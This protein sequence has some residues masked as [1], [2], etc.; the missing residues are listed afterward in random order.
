MLS[1]IIGREDQ[2]LILLYVRVLSIE[3][4]PEKVRFILLSL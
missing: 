3:G 2:Q 1:A 4:R